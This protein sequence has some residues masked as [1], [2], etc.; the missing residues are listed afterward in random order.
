MTSGRRL[1]GEGR[2]GGVSLCKVEIT[3]E[4]S[5][6]RSGSGYSASEFGWGID[7]E[8]GCVDGVHRDVRKASHR[9]RRDYESGQ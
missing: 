6:D 4:V 2:A 7:T 3:I 1:V 8:G 9:E 5:E